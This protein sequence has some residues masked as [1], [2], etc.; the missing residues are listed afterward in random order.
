MAFGVTA[1]GATSPYTFKAEWS[2]G[3]VQTNNVGTF[4][5]TFQQGQSIPTSVT[6]IVS[7]S[8]KQSTTV[9]IQ[10]PASTATSST[11]SEELQNSSNVTF[12]ESGLPSKFNWSVTMNKIT[13]SSTSNEINFSGL[14][15]GKYDFNTTYYFDGNF[16]SAFEY[17]PSSGSLNVNSSNQIV[18]ILF[19]KISQNQILTLTQRPVVSV[20]NDTPSI[21]FIYK[22]NLPAQLQCDIF[23]ILNDSSGHLITSATSGISF[24]PDSTSTGNLIFTSLAPG[25]YSATVLVESS[26]EVISQETIVDV[27][28]P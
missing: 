20:A 18:R 5:R 9:V 12:V 1:N 2:D 26:G 15:N 16:S 10:I 23:A 22:N 13:E 7:S 17:A 6:V 4:S 21:S 24:R 8:D 3:F 28:I 25:N 11:S 27:S 14:T 19:S